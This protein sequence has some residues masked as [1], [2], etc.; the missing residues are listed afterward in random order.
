MN[1]IPRLNKIDETYKIIDTRPEPYAAAYPLAKNAINIPHT[2]NAF[3]GM[4]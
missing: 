4:I 2:G 1:N 3:V